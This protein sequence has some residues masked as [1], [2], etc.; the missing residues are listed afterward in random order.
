MSE[1]GRVS[2]AA[3][4]GQDKG[5][6]KEGRDVEV[7]VNARVPARAVATKPYTSQ[8]LGAIGSEAGHSW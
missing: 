3:A 1:K 4:H 5:A 2:V 6:G 8:T 7:L